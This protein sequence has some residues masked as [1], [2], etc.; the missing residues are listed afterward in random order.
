[1][2]ILKLE[3]CYYNWIYYWF[4]LFNNVYGGFICVRRY[5]S[6]WGDNGK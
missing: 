3:K 4:D 2:L 1:M 5:S 6:F